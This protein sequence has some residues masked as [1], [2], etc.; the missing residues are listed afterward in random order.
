MTKPVVVFGI[1]Q[2]A[3][4]AHFYLEHDSPH[5]VVAFTVDRP[6]LTRETFHGRPVLAWDEL[7]RAYPPSAVSLF[8][9]ISFKRMNHIRADKVQEAKLR[10]YDLVSYVSSKATTFP[11][12]SCGEN[13]FIL[14]GN[15]IQ[16]F[17][18][19]GRDVV[20]WTGNYVGHHSVIE[21]HV[22]IT[23]HVAIAGACRIGAHAFLGTNATIRDETVIGRETIVGAGVVVLADTEPFSVL[24]RVNFELP[25]RTKVR[26][27]RA[28][29]ARGTDW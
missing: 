19:I 11:G 13:C 23:A 3:E 1:G 24:T 18:E 5:D 25:S 27:V 29:E 20:M 21:D 9:P 7:E 8:V 15:V 12:F 16:P 6:Y 4:L 14:E 2:W 17:I 22:M 28:S 10:G 26:G